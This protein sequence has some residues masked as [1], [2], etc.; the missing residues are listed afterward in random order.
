MK[1]ILM[2]LVVVGMLISA[3][4]EKEIKPL[5]QT[6]TKV[7]IPIKKIPVVIGMTLQRFLL[8]EEGKNARLQFHNDTAKIKQQLWVYDDGTVYEDGTVRGQCF[9]FHD[10]ILIDWQ[11]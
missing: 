9:L 8:S 6:K 10:E 4:C 5:E 7:S 3:G 11:N 1:K 2:M